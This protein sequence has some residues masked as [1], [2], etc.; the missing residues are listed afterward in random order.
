GRR[1]S[2]TWKRVP[3]PRSRQRSSRRGRPTYAPRHG[4]WARA[5]LRFLLRRPGHAAGLA[6]REPLGGRGTRG[7][8]LQPVVGATRARRELG[9][10][11]VCRLPVE[12]AGADA[13][14]GAGFGSGLGERILDA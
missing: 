4:E 1:A 6:G 12:L 11:V 7:L 3:S 8:V 13:H 9:V 14:R 2:R 5:L 10:G